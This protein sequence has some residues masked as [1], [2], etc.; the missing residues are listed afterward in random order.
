ML[1][2]HLKPCQSKKLN[3]D[4]RIMAVDLANH[5]IQGRRGAG[6]GT[7]LLGL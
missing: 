4:S 3:M 6:R 2:S 5:G 7:Q 1:L